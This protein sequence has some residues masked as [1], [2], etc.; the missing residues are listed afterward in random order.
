MYPL[1]KLQ[2]AKNV[3]KPSTARP[4]R[5]VGVTY[6]DGPNGIPGGAIEF[7]G[8]PH[9][10]LQFPNGGA[11]DTK[12]SITILCWVY[13]LGKSGPLFNYRPRS[14]GVHL[15]VKGSRT[16][17]ARIV[18][19]SGKFTDY[20]SKR[21]L[22]LK[23]WSFVGVSY[24]YKTGVVKLWNNGVVVSSRKIGKTE[25]ATQQA[26]RMG[27]RIGDRRYLKARVSCLQVYRT[28]LTRGQVRRAT[29]MCMPSGEWKFVT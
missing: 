25:I 23:K 19:R 18:K 11:L 13:P 1:N 20:V 24:S 10:Y 6:R 28:A 22:N 17:F 7:R 26:V 3:V 12:R 27:V 21:V 5:V 8:T 4:G 2:K 9:S 15:W 16:L 14:Y 29:K